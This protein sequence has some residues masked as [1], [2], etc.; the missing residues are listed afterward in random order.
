MEKIIANFDEKSQNL[1][2]SN[3]SKINIIHQY[4]VFYPIIKKYGSTKI[5]FYV[6]KIKSIPVIGSVLFNFK[7][8]LDKNEKFK[9]IYKKI[10]NS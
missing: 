2:N 8:K 6:R 9:Q 5:P 3:K 7:R 1:L 4:D 10:R